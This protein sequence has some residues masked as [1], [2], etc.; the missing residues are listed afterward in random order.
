MHGGDV[1]FCFLVLISLIGIGVYTCTSRNSRISARATIVEVPDIKMALSKHRLWSKERCPRFLFHLHQLQLCFP[2]LC[3]PPL[4]KAARENNVDLLCQLIELGHDVNEGDSNG[5]TALHHAAEEGNVEVIDALLLAGA[6]RTVEDERGFTPLHVAAY[7]SQPDSVKCLLHLHWGP[8]ADNEQE[9]ERRL[10]FVDRRDASGRAA[11]HLA[12]YRSSRETVLELLRG[13]SDVNL[14]DFKKSMPLHFAASN[15]FDGPPVIQ[16]LLEW[17]AN[18][19]SFNDSFYTPLIFAVMHYNVNAVRELLAASAN[20]N[21]FDPCHRTALS[22]SAEALNTSTGAHYVALCCRGKFLREYSRIDYLLI[23][24]HLLSVPSLRINHCDTDTGTAL[25][26]AAEANC[27]EG[28]KL[29]LENGAYPE[30]RNQ[31][32]ELPGDLTQVD[33]IRNLLRNFNR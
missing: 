33:E 15:K 3:Y 19:D 9:N 18:V 31:K 8:T 7:E 11:L 22:I 14:L 1:D 26:Y 20:V 10:K 5:Q 32:R 27:F 16:L 12:A 6:D 25:H 13:G 2:P 21:I 29:L 24:K 30:I 17:G 28:V 23:L 4:A